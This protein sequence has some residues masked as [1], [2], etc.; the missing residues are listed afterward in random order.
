MRFFVAVA[1]VTSLLGC[2]DSTKKPPAVF[3]DAPIPPAPDAP[4]SFACTVTP[5]SNVSVR[6]VGSIGSSAMLATSP[7]G[8]GRLFVV[9]QYGKIRIFKSGAL[10]PTAFLDISADAG[11]KVEAGGEMGL[12][13]LAFHPQYATNRQFYVYY[14]AR[15]PDTS[16]DDPYINTVVRYTASATDPDR[17]ELAS[18]QT[19][20][21]IPDFASNH[22]GGMIE[23]GSDGMLYIGTGDGGGGGDPGRHGQNRNTLLGKMLRLDVDR[24][25]NGRNY[26]IPTDNPYA[27]G[28]AGAPEVYVYGLRN[29]WRWTFD[30]MTGDMWIGDVGQ[31]QYEEVHVLPAGQ[32]AGKNLGWP[33]YEGDECCADLPGDCSQSPAPACDPTGKTPAQDKRS[34]GDGW[35]AIIGGQVYR[36]QCYP[37]LAGWSFYT[38]NAKRTMIKARLKTDGSLEI[39]DLPTPAGNWPAG[40][41]SIHADGSGELF[42]TTTSGDVFRIEASQ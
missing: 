13:G 42:L 39:V 11:G 19:V 27:D 24:P 33:V 12:L 6:N 31:G 30:T 10:L 40:A 21:A 7:P 14:T 23:F 2:K 34:H 26:G 9:D 37:D 1:L 25:A 38:D 35:R 28:V 22:N 20:I 41:A 16:S 8:D 36:G 3:E 15:N 17:A 4:P 18:E 5:G 29:P 32:I